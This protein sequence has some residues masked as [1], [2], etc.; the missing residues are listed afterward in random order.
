MPRTAIAQTFAPPTGGTLAPVVEALSRLL[1]ASE[2][3]EPDSAPAKAYR[4]AMRRHAEQALAN[5]GPQVLHYLVAHIR[6]T[7]PARADVRE[8]ILSAAWS[9]IGGRP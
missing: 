2:P 3:H 4:S 7:D 5:G 1:T 9:G 6:E 8:A